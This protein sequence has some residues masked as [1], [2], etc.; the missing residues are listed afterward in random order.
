MATT[1]GKSGTTKRTTAK[2]APARRASPKRASL[3]PKK[4]PAVIR[5][6]QEREA[7]VDIRTADVHAGDDIN[8]D[9][10]SGVRDIDRSDF[11]EVTGEDMTSPRVQSYANELRFMEDIMTISI[12]ETDDPNA[13]NPVSC[14]VN[15]EVRN[16]YRGQEYKVARKFVDSI[17][18]RSFAVKTKQYTDGEGLVQTKIEKVPTLKYPIN[19]HHDPAG[20]TGRDWFQWM[21]KTAL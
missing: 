12:A 7:Q 4:A 15:G 17:I 2:K 19:I 10:S 14:G 6:Q 1:Q 16:F 9:I 18:K 11:A 5:K 3:A 8:I 20:Q 13:E 21:C